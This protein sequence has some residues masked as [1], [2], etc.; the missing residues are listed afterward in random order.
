[1]Q[2]SAKRSAFDRAVA[3]VLPHGFELLFLL[4]VQDS[5]NLAV[6]VLN[7]R[8]CLGAPIILRD[9]LVLEE[10]LKLLLTVNQQGLDL[11]LLVGCQVECL[12]HV[13]QL[14]VGIHVPWAAGAML[15]LVWR[16]GRGFLGQG[17]AA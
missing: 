4:V 1:M 9:R 13:L 5:L 14:P 3:H 2:P 15:G 16:W 7:D 12:R 17:R 6:L 11:A 8:P 10:R